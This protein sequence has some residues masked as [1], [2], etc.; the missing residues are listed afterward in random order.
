VGAALGPAAVGG[1]HLLFIRIP[2]LA[3][4]LA[5]TLVRYLL[6]SPFTFALDWFVFA[7]PGSEDQ[8]RAPVS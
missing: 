8:D 3:R 6:I 4:V 2:Q 5:L 1:A 7:A